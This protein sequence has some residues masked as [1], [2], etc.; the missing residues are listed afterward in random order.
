M[1]VTRETDRVEGMLTGEGCQ[2][3]CRVQVSR[4]ATY[5]ESADPLF[6]TYS[7][8]QIE[9]ADDFPDGHYELRFEDVRLLLTKQAGQYLLLSTPK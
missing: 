9:D 8:F 7:R 1:S 4:C 6:V 5:D 3:A 2:R